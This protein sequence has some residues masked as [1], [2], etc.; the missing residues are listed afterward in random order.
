LQSR[1]AQTPN[2]YVKKYISAANP[3][4]DSAHESNS[5]SASKRKADSHQEKVCAIE[6]KNALNPV[7]KD[8]VLPLG[9]DDYIGEGIS[10]KTSD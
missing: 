9:Q 8:L 7:T 2:G 6:K 1:G 4:N 10:I 3:P 5:H